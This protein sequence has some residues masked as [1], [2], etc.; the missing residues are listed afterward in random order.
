MKNIVPATLGTL[1]HATVSIGRKMGFSG[2]GGRTRGQNSGMKKTAS[3]QRARWKGPQEALPGSA[4]FWENLAKPPAPSLPAG[5]GPHWG[6]RG[7]HVRWAICP[8][9]PRTPGLTKS[10]YLMKLDDLAN[11]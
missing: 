8:G 7:K 6:V 3:A 10:H 9:P 1:R 5:A 11:K 4:G 2:S